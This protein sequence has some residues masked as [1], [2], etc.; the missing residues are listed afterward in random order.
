MKKWLLVL[1]LICCVAPELMAQ[2]CAVCTKT[3]S[4]LDDKAA[5]GL[6]GGILYLALL[7]LGIMGTVGFIWWRNNKTQI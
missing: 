7:P 3:A 5:R 1:A 2:G 6:N 4:T